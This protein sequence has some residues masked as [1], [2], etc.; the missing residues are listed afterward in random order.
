MT[1]WTI[2]TCALEGASFIKPQTLDWPLPLTGEVYMDL[3]PAPG[4]SAQRVEF[5]LQTDFSGRFS[6]FSS[7]GRFELQFFSQAQ[8]IGSSGSE[9]LHLL[10]GAVVRHRPDGEDTE[11][12][13]ALATAQPV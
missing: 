4:E 6:A 1:H 13:S 5:E 7:N 8:P 10:T 3:L 9:L 12:F 2:S 11:C